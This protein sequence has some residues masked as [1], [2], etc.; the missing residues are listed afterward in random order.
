[1]ARFIARVEL[2]GIGSNED[3]VAL[4][5]ELHNHM[6]GARFEPFHSSPSLRNQL[7][8]PDGHYIGEFDATLTE[9]RAAVDEA[10]KRI[11]KNAH[12]FVVQQAPNARARRIDP[13]IKPTSS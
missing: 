3:A 10:V 12:V 13:S 2:L 9:A 7:P 5:E 1:M 6:R 8:W 4:Y 11:R